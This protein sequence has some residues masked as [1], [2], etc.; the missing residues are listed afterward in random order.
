MPSS[1]GSVTGWLGSLRNRADP[2]ASQ[3]LW[4]RY[5]VQL[6]GVA[7]QRLGRAPRRAADE[8]DVAAAAFASFYRGVEAN[9]FSQLHDR[10]DLWQILLVLTERKAFNQIRHELAERRGAGKVL[11]ESVLD[12]AAHGAGGLA[13]VAD[14]GPTPAFA[15]EVSEQLERLLQS[16]GEPVLRQIALLKLEGYTNREIAERLSVSLRSV[17]RRLA[18][19]RGIW[20]Q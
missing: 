16:L 14:P 4:E 20:Q 19:I 13:N 17:E 9:R 3:R 15:I 7:R 8:E 11:G 18:L 1:S 12:D 2:I 10:D 6:I 5:I